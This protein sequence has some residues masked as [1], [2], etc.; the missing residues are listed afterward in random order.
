MTLKL[1]KVDDSTLLILIR[2]RN[3]SAF[4]CLFNRYF[5]PLCRFI[6][7][8]VKD[9]SS[10][11]ELALDIF[12][13]LWENAEAIEIKRTFKSYLYQSARNRSLNHLRDRKETIALDS[14]LYDL[15]DTDETSMEVMEL[16]SLIQEA[17]LALPDRCRE[18]FEKSR[19]EEL[20]NK[21]ISEDLSISI[22]TVEAQITKALKRLKEYVEKGY[23]LFF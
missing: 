20:S 3:E 10:S 14:I 2:T 17:V 8:Y 13:Y 16:E 9:Y 4:K 19:Y 18:V 5:I 12:T 6:N 11:E 22:K 7:I 21:Q 1:S 15:G 23:M